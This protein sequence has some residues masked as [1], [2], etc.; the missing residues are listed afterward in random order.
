LCEW[1]S[2]QAR[3]SGAGRHINPSVPCLG[4]YEERKHPVRIFVDELGRGT[5]YDL[6]AKKIAELSLSSII[7]GSR[8]AKKDNEKDINNPNSMHLR[9][10]KGNQCHPGIR[11][12]GEEGAALK[13]GVGKEG[14]QISFQD[15][16]EST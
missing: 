10:V 9:R 11:L 14:V 15:L 1:R 4:I 6:E 12:V 3:V 2:S 5:N 16:I 7:A 13:E 8:L